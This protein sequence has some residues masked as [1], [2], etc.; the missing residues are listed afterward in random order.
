MIERRWDLDRRRTSKRRSNRS[1]RTKHSNQT[2]NRS[3]CAHTRADETTKEVD[4]VNDVDVP[5]NLESADP[6]LETGIVA[7]SNASVGIEALA[8]QR[9]VDL[10]SVADV[11]DGGEGVGEVEDQE[12]ADEAGDA[13]EV[14][15]G[16]GDDEGD[17][18]VDGA[19]GIPEEL[20]FLG[21]DF[22]PFEDFLA[23]FDVDGLHADVEV[24]HC[25][26]D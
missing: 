3:P 22:G 23:D 7:G 5:V 1:A 25:G 20:A 13:V 9:G 17:D 19:Q 26:C 11:E 8:W 2:L 15:D 24:E 6:A 21:G 10:A 18:P 16:G 12:G 4:R 14:G